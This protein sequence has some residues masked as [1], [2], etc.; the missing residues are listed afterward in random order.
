MATETWVGQQGYAV[1]ANLATVATSGSYNDLSNKPTLGT[2]AAKNTVDYTTEVTNKPD[3]SVYA[4]SSSLAAVA[5]SGSYNDLL[6]KP[7]IPTD[8]SDLTNGAGFITSSALTNYVTKSG[9]ETISGNKYFSSG[10]SV[11]SGINTDELNIF[12]SVSSGT[13]LIN[14][15]FNNG[16]DPVI[17]MNLPTTDPQEINQL[18]NDN[19]I[20]KMS[21][22]SVDY[23][24]T[25][26]AQTITGEKTLNFSNTTSYQGE[27]LVNSFDLYKNANFGSYE[28]K[29]RENGKYLYLNQDRVLLQDTSSSNI[30]SLYAGYI[31]HNNNAIYLPA[32]A[33]TL[34]L[35]SQI[36]T[37]LPVE[38]LTTAPSAAYTGPGLKVVY[39]S[40]EPATKYAGYIY[41]IAEA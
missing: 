30:T 17:K 5:T 2:L 9:A 21:G 7:T 16:T 8:T 14:A 19:G 23:V 26:T 13:L 36:P 39:L 1:A 6:N 31:L 25:N 18:W 38:V 3:L 41:M 40:A 12:D 29:F 20:I 32:S 24:T 10:I 34:A 11:Q 35:T 27:S 28:I 37:S 33:G 22:A 4:L 15:Y